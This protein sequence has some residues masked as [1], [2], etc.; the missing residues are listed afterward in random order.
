MIQ[1]YAEQTKCPFPLYTDPTRNLYKEL[2]MTSTFAMGPRPDYDRRG[3]LGGIVASLWNNVRQIPSGKALSGGD[4]K[5]VGGEFLFEPVGEIMTSPV[6]SP[7]LEAEGKQLGA[8][9]QPGTLDRSEEKRI[10]WCH[11][12]RNTR[13][14]AEIP[15]L[16]EV[17]GL[18]GHGN[19]A[20]D[21]GKGARARRWSRA[22]QERK[23]TG[24]SQMN[25]MKGSS[26]EVLT[27]CPSNA[28]G[29]SPKR[30]G[31]VDEPA[32]ALAKGEG[33]PETVGEEKNVAIP[34]TS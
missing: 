9:I 20:V 16:R 10:T 2:G 31:Q 22:V 32:G 7:V 30:S 21:G 12:M 18:D 4:Y 33:V 1:Q 24:I 8:G 13:D 6:A 14:H 34:T 25:G 19:E 5:Q 3:T 29:D 15:E 28:S 26:G 17:L 27:G 23:G 11:R